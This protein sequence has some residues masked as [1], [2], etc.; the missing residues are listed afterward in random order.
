M[1]GGDI[2]ERQGVTDE[3]TKCGWGL[4][5]GAMLQA[6]APGLARGQQTLAHDHPDLCL[7]GGVPHVPS[8]PP[9]PVWWEAGLTARDTRN[10]TIVLHDIR[11][12]TNVLKLYYMSTVP[13]D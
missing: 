9:S 8:K 5:Y 12:C 7:G 3:T 10:C 13:L 4:K 11:N 1:A 6:P 2:R